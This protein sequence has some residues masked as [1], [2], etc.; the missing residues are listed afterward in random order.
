MGFAIPLLAFRVPVQ[1]SNVAAG[2]VQTP[3]GSV[4]P[5]AGWWRLGRR[6]K[7]HPKG[8]KASPLVESPKHAGRS[9]AV[10]LGGRIAVQPPAGRFTHA[11]CALAPTVPRHRQEGKPLQAREGPMCLRWLRVLAGLP[12]LIRVSALQGSPGNGLRALHAH[13]WCEHAMICA[14]PSPRRH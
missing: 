11:H 4:K 12:Q 5:D 6:G 13:S 2:V 9:Q 7:T 3:T 8:L 1:A 10:S 14:A